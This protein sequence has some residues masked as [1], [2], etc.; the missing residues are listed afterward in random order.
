MEELNLDTFQELL[1]KSRI[2]NKY[3]IR[4]ISLF[5]SFI[6]GE[7]FNDIDILIED[8]RDYNALVDFKQELESLT[9]KKVDLMI[10]KYANPIV[11]YRAQ[12]DLIHVTAN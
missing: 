4:K 7:Q 2:L 9:H 1:K 5:G 10:K 12:K 6:K 3:G 8:A 11:L